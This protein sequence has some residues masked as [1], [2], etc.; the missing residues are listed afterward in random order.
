[1]ERCPW[2]REVELPGHAVIIVQ[3][4]ECFNE[5]DRRLSPTVRAEAVRAS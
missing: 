2:D 3:Q 1:M 5:A 4:L